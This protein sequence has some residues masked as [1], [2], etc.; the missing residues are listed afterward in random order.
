MR[1]GTARLV[2]R[3]IDQLEAVPLSGVT[4]ARAPFFSPDGKWIGFFDGT[5]RAMKKVSVA[6]GSVI[7][8]CALNEPAM[9]TTPDAANGEQDRQ[10]PSILPGGQAIL[11]TIS[12][13]RAP[14]SFR[15]RQMRTR[16]SGSGARA[17][18]TASVSSTR[19]PHRSSKNDRHHAA[20]GL[21][22]REAG[23]RFSRDLPGRPLTT[24]PCGDCL[25][26]SPF[27]YATAHYRG[28]PTAVVQPAVARQ[29]SVERPT[30][31]SGR[32]RTVG[33]AGP[34]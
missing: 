28:W 33:P 30:R 8:I 34:W 31:A 27:H 5:T 15:A 26:L 2:I 1:P 25:R 16:S 7:P 9:L 19:R 32:G 3:G 24:C 18:S 14:A 20:Q 6:G 11:F 10:Q 22:C 17:Y 23:R 12:T 13:Y 4:D 29:A 21:R